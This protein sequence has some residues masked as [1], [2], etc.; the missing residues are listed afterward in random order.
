M[1][2]RY[3]ELQIVNLWSVSNMQQQ[4]SNHSTNR[5]T[6]ATIGAVFHKIK[7]SMFLSSIE[8]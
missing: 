5:A 8:I 6:D 2:E 7:F 3:C 1:Q 4:E